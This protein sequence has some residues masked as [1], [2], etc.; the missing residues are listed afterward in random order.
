V[1]KYI[2]GI[3]LSIKPKL[4]AID[5]YKIN[6]YFGINAIKI[7]NQIAYHGYIS[8]LKK[9]RKKIKSIERKDQRKTLSLFI[10]SFFKVLKKA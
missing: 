6:L 3:Y 7:K 10:F 2:Y 4:S 5:E 1:P 8:S 9:E